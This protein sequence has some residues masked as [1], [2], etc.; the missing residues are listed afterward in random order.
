MFKTRS[1]KLEEEAKQENLT[2]TKD[3]EVDESKLS[4]EEKGKTE[5]PW[6]FVIIAG[7]IALIMIGIFITIFA[8]GGPFN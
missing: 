1:K 2:P 4:E 7:S 5:F 6:L 3:L 8:I